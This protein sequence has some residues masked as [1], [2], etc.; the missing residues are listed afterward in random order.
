MPTNKH[1]LQRAS[2]INGEKKWKGGG[3]IQREEKDEGSSV[4][5]TALKQS[6]LMLREI[7]MSLSDKT[8]YL[9]Q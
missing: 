1:T 2:N 9:K 5:H 8:V 6:S 4:L 3:K 7:M